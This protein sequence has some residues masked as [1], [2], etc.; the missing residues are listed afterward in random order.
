MPRLGSRASHGSPTRRPEGPIGRAHCCPALRAPPAP[1][2]PP[3]ARRPPA[4]RHSLTHP[5]GQP[6][7]RLLGRRL[8]PRPG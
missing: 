7:S 1:E 2:G 3:S 4:A 6:H 5:L 8:K